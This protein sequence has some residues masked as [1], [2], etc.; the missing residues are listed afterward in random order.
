MPFGKSCVGN[1]RNTHKKSK[2]GLDGLCQN[3]LSCFPSHVH[4]RTGA[5]C[6]FYS[7]AI[8]YEFGRLP[9]QNEP[10]ASCA[11]K[12]EIPRQIH[13]TNPKMKISLRSDGEPIFL[14]PHRKQALCL[15]CLKKWDSPSNSR[16][17]PKN[18]NFT[19][20]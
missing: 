10:L 1:P 11:S 6:T 14:A 19:Q 13:G 12:N 4:S 5:S 8:V 18:E 15:S 3:R 7:K 9:C 17:K 20:K 16:D 2:T